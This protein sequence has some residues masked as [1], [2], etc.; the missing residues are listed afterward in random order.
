MTVEE[1][2]AHMMGAADNVVALAA[3]GAVLLAIVAAVA[4]VKAVW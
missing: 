2:Q 4:L 1:Y 3:V